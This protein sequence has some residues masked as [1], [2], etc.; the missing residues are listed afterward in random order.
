MTVEW[1]KNSSC[2]SINYVKYSVGE[3][4]VMNSSMSNFVRLSL[5][6]DIENYLP[7]PHHLDERTNFSERYPKQRVG[8]VTK[9]YSESLNK[10]QNPISLRQVKSVSTDTLDMNMEDNLKMN[11][12]KRENII[13]EQQ[14]D[15]AQVQTLVFYLS[16][17]LMLNKFTENITA[18]EGESLLD[19][20]F[21]HHCNH[22]QRKRQGQFPVQQR[23]MS[24]D[25]ENQEDTRSQN[26]SYLKLF[27]DKY[28]ETNE[29]L[30]INTIA[31]V[32][33]SQVKYGP[34]NLKATLVTLDNTWLISWDKPESIDSEETTFSA[35][36]G[37]V[38]SINGIEMKRI[39]SVNVTK[40]II[41]LS[42]S[43]KYPVILKIQLT[44]E[45]NCLSA[46]ALITLD[47]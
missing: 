46:P 30:S 39:S 9:G 42:E 37:Y 27:S 11:N 2:P 6:D 34:R 35:I 7:I 33:N 38:L 14:K 43:V 21:H 10:I 22:P 15:I 40:S 25:T 5:Y 3:L 17:Q 26:N 31:S 23:T 29:Q 19:D 8:I 44:D 28:T 32:L 41:N 47:V 45:N 24:D 13:L 18:T 16:E 20:P 36:T 1:R 12:L 4:T